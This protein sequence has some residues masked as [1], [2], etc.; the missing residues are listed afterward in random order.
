MN[1]RFLLTTATA[2]LVSSS[3]GLTAALAQDTAAADQDAG[4][5]I[6]DMVLGN[7]DATVEVIEYA[8]FTCPHCANFHANQFKEIKK[9]YIDTGKIKFVYRE[10][11]FDRFGLWASMIA[12][13]GGEMRYFGI[14]DMIYE[15]QREWTA[16]GDPV[17]IADNLRNIGKVAGL[18]DA[19]L[20][21]CMQDGEKA[22]AL[23]SWFEENSTRDEIAS[24]PSFMING[25]KYSNMSYEDFAALLDKAL[26]G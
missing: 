4:V 19:D 11:Y 2:A 15:K 1:R 10:I 24:T 21:A 9:N 12:R 13:C 5:Q 20:D 14:A 18:S 17:V 8:S 26:E 7:P 22:Q 3:L 16:G 23:V 25:E 6:T